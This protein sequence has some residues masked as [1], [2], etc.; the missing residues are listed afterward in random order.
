MTKLRASAKEIYH[1][2]WFYIL[3]N[4]K[5]SYFLLDIENIWLLVGQINIVD[6]FSIRSVRSKP[7]SIIFFKYYTIWMLK[8]L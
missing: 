1:Y 8:I 4:R 2:F 6:D 7:C 3:G 5:I